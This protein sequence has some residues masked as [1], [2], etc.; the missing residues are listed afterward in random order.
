[1]YVFRKSDEGI[2]SMK[3]TNKS[4]QPKKDGHPLA[5]SVERSPETKGNPCQ[6]PVPGIQGLE[7]TSSRLA[8]I[9]EAA[10]RDP[11][12]RFTCLLHHLSVGMLHR[13]FHD[14]N[15]GAA[16]GVDRVTWHEYNDG[17]NKRLEDL[18]SRACISRWA[19]ICSTP[20]RTTISTGFQYRNKKLDL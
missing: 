1:M 4:A 3:Q 15:K 13:A 20:N 6:L 18:H 2:V 14:L 8:R 9:R 11:T 7:P 17:L 16:A 19:G 5:E 10:R 12:L